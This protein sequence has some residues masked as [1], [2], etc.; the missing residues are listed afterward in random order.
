[1]CALLLHSFGSALGIDKLSTSHCNLETLPQRAALSYNISLRPPLSLHPPPPPHSSSSHSIALSPVRFC[2]TLVRPFSKGRPGDVICDH[3]CLISVCHDPPFNFD[4]LSSAFR[5]QNRHVWK[6][7]DSKLLIYLPSSWYFPNLILILMCIRCCY[8]QPKRKKG[9]TIPNIFFNFNIP[10]S[11][12][13][14][15]FLIPTLSSPFYHI[16]FFCKSVPLSQPNYCYINS[17]SSRLKEMQTF[18]LGLTNFKMIYLRR[19]DDILNFTFTIFSCIILELFGKK[20]EDGTATSDEKLARIKDLCF[21]CSKF[22]SFFCARRIILQ[23]SLLF[24]LFHHQI[25]P[26]RFKQS[27]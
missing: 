19:F 26:E 7:S 15:F 2:L 24:L 6:R 25:D 14:L 18:L 27:L 1:M 17:L 10:T 11:Q 21:F 4:P 13:F 5:C 22:S 20:K 16:I 8:L 23:A 9:Q 3:A 12:I